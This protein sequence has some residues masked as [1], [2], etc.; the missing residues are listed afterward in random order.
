[1]SRVNVQNTYTEASTY[2]TLPARAIVSLSSSDF[3]S[4]TAHGVVG[5]Q[6]EFRLSASDPWLITYTGSPSELLVG[7]GPVQVRSDRD[8]R[9][10]VISHTYVV[11]EDDTGRD[12]EAD[13]V[14]SFDALTDKAT[15]D[16][17][18]T[19]TSVANAL[20]LKAPLASPALTGAPTAPTA[21]PGTNTTQLATTAFVR[22][23]FTNLIAG[24]PG[25]LDT[26]DEI[27]AA[28]NDD[29]NLAATLTAAIALKDDK[30]INEKTVVDDTYTVIESDAKKTI[31]F[32]HA[33]GCVVTHAQGLSVGHVYKGI[34]GV[35]AG[36]I[37]LDD[38]G[39]AT[40]VS[41]T[42]QFVTTGANSSYV[43]EHLSTNIFLAEGDLGSLV[44]AD[45]SDFSE[46]LDDRVNALIS[47]GTGITKNY[48]DSGNLLSISATGALSA[49]PWEMGNFECAVQYIGHNV[50]TTSGV[51]GFAA[52]GGTMAPQ[53]GLW[54][55]TNYG[56]RVRIPT[57]SASVNLNA[58]V[59]NSQPTG[60]VPGTATTDAKIRISFVFAA[61]DAT[62]GCRIGAGFKIG[63]PSATVE[64]S[65]FTDCGEICG[66][67]TDTNLRFISN[68]ATATGANVS[69]GG[70][71]P[72]D[73]GPYVGTLMMEGGGA[74]VRKLTYWVKNLTNGISTTGS[75]TVAAELPTAG[76]AVHPFVY[77]NSAA[78]ASVVN[79]DFGNICGGYKSGVQ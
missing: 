44:A 71:F 67:S 53:T 4:F 14:S 46:A 52:T 73:G 6:V 49:P 17:V 59:T 39:V 43:V 50:L 47:A 54:N 48:D 37:T 45:I 75:T 70:D 8:A 2:V 66:D 22:T 31:T 56:Q 41:K 69:L 21:A 26:L 63:N 57:A 15:A 25:T 10:L 64:P 28:L 65:L 11:T 27:A 51:N 19:N 24:A 74:G 32:T 36:V 68:D 3:V 38:D 58:S 77:R 61:G 34:Q 1:M 12:I 16:I 5:S 33:S 60:Y 42:G 23:E 30:I 35:G 55:G 18:G 20:A 72:K 78:N 62:S 29:A 79:L 9:A 40:I 13:G 76:S 7:T